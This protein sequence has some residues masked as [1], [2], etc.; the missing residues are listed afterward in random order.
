[1]TAI[2][3]G[4]EWSGRLCCSLAVTPKCQNTCA[5]SSNARETWN[6]CRRSDEQSLFECFTRQE[7]GDDCCGNA[8]TSE[9][10]QVRSNDIQ[11]DW[12]I[13]NG[14]FLVLHPGMSQYIPESNNGHQSATAFH[15]KRLQ[16]Q[17]HQFEGAELCQT[18][19]WSHAHRQFTTM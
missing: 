15:W 17:Q 6:G 16:W 14:F 3:H 8:R 12:L 7:K 11:L 2:A 13:L 5:T 19:D 9:C 1:M 18:G 4:S 10:L